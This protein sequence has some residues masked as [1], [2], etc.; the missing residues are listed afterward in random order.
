MRAAFLHRLGSA[1]VGVFV[2]SCSQSHVSSVTGLRARA[3]ADE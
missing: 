2:V 3:P 1:V